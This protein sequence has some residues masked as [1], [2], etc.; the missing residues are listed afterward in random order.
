MDPQKN[1][2]IFDNKLITAILSVCIA[3][4]LWLYVVTTNSTDFEAPFYNIDVVHLNDSLL[5]ERGLMIVENQTPEVDLT[6]VGN[7]TDVNKL[8]SSNITV[9]V[10]LSTIWEP[11]TVALEFKVSYPGDIPNNSINIQSRNPSRVTLKLEQR[12]TKPVKVEVFYANSVPEG[13]IADKENVELEY[14]ELLISG[15]KSVMDQVAYA[16]IDVDLKDQ[17]K[18][19][20]GQFPFTLCNEAGDPVDAA[21]ISVP[22][23]EIGLALKIQRVKEI[24]L[25]VNVEDGGGATS[26]TCDINCII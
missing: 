3:F 26:K 6:L 24:T 8:N 9:T 12:I 25:K 21:M 22:V 4:G 16:R 10:D 2:S 14:Q 1:K 11:G 5:A 7:R 20:G 15:P 17:S 23:E 13:F 19:F 18:S